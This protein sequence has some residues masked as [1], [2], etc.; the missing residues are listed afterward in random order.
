[1]NDA[2]ISGY[3]AHV[4]FDAETRDT[5]WGLRERLPDLFPAAGVG[6]FHERTVGPHPAWSFQIAFPKAL[7]AELI[8]WLMLNRQGLTVFVHAEGG[9]V[10]RDHT[11][12]VMWLGPS[13]TLDLAALD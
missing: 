9:D 1:M 13:R 3:H 2:E 12:H 11:E 4:Y 6:R 10:I 7:F 8:P 5:A